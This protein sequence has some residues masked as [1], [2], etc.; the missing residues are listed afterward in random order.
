MTLEFHH[1]NYVSQDVD[2]LDNFYL[3]VMKM[4]NIAPE[5]FPRTSAT[6]AKG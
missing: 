2:E 4:E 5:K 3:N 1:I 6:N